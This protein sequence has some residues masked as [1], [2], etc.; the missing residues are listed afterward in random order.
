MVNMDN[1]YKCN[2]H[3]FL[4]NKTKYVNKPTIDA[5]LEKNVLKNKHFSLIDLF[6]LINKV[7]KKL[8]AKKSNPFKYDSP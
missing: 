5:I 2:M 1:I 8:K 7:K 4:I 6:L 3:T